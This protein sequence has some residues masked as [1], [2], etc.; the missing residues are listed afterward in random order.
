MLAK[1]YCDGSFLYPEP[2]AFKPKLEASGDFNSEQSVNR[3]VYQFK[4]MQIIITFYIAIF[5]K[6][7]LRV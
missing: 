1:Y 6:G 4:K 5:T 7:F 2:L 3:F